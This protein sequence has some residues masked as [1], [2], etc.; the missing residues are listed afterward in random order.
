M[1]GR[2]SAR[3][4]CLLLSSWLTFSQSLLILPTSKLRPSG[5][6]SRWLVLY[7]FQDPVSLSKE[8][9]CEAG[10]FSCPLNPHRFFQSEV[11]RLYF[12][13]LDPGVHGLSGSPVAPPGLSACKCGTAH[14]ISCCLTW[15]L[16]W[17]E[18]PRGALLHD[19]HCVFPTPSGSQKVNCVALNITPCYCY[20]NYSKQETFHHC[21]SG[22]SIFN[23][24]KKKP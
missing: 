2:G 19:W 3:E 21:Y 16:S 23:I 13:T 22:T 15:A 1:W 18:L 17:A 7:T 24:N 12:P 5:A 8:L 9:S 4:Q 6:G 14:S 20:R 11:L 10:S